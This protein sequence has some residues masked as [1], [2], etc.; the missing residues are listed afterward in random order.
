MKEIYTLDCG[1][2]YVWIDKYLK[3]YTSIESACTAYLSLLEDFGKHENLYFDEE[4]TSEMVLAEMKNTFGIQTYYKGACE[5][6]I[7]KWELEE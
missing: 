6:I 7:Q 5:V 4:E 1:F 2:Y 3:A